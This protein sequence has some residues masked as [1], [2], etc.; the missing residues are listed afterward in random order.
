MNVL[1]EQGIESKNMYES[2][3]G[4]GVFVTEADIAFPDLENITAVEKDILSGRVLTALG[5]SIP[6]PVSVQIKGFEETLNEEN[7]KADSIISNI[8]LGN[9]RVFYKVLCSS[10][11]FNH[12]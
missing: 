1:K 9:F 10:N 11:K 5:S 8:P 6:V 3:S 2:S 12:E 4:A 7:C